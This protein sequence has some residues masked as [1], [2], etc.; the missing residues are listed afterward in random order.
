MIGFGI[1]IRVS[2]RW[3][4]WAI[5][6]FASR[7]WGGGSCLRGVEGGLF[8][9]EYWHLVA[10]TTAVSTHSTGIHSWYRSPSKLREVM[11]LHLSVSHSIHRGC[12]PACMWAGSVS[13]HALRRGWVGVYGDVG[14]RGCGFLGT[15]DR[16]VWTWGIPYWN[17]F[18]F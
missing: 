12:I 11:F 13:Q 15:V 18:L 1:R 10:A 14:D 16:G 17:A 6:G 2:L 7:R 9:P 4:K 8:N 3:W 5:S